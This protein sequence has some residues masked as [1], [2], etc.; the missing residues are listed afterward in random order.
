MDDRLNGG[1]RLACFIHMLEMPP[2]AE[3]LTVGK[4]ESVDAAF[5][6]LKKEHCL[7]FQR[8]KLSLLLVILLLT[9]A[10]TTTWNQLLEQTRLRMALT[11][12]LISQPVASRM[13]SIFQ[14][15]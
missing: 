13:A 5:R 1:P 11:T 9:M 15:L 4:M 8:Q 3:T 10:I 12:L 7:I 6:L 2:A 14:T